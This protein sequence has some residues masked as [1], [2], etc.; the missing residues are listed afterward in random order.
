MI[1]YDM[2]VQH[3]R[4]RVMRRVSGSDDHC[5]VMLIIIMITMMMIIMMRIMMIMIKI[6][7][8]IIINIISSSYS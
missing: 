4:L 2:V 1:N 5:L 7:V 6:I 3:D 8:M